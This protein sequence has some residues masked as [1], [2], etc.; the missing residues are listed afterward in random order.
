MSQVE[1]K[2]LLEVNLDPQNY[3]NTNKFSP[4][5]STNNKWFVNLSQCKILHKVQCLLQ[6][7]QNFSL[8]SLNTI[9]NIIQLIKNI[10]N[11]IIKLQADTQNVIRNWSVLHNFKS[12]S[13][14]KDHTDLIYKIINSIKIIN[15]II[16]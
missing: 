13:L 4:L 8:L 2:D 3:S 5:E 6:L 11:N 12:F 7:E 14:Y 16:H 15:K 9:N 10:E 1:R